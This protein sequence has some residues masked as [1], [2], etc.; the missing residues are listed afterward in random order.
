M[1]V[2]VCVF[3]CVC[4]LAV[5]FARICPGLKAVCVCVCYFVE[6]R[7]RAAPLSPY[8]YTCVY[9]YAY[10]CVYVYFYLQMY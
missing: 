4:V 8:K 6:N 1:C 3:E 9:V 7:V 2:C 10:V 5:L